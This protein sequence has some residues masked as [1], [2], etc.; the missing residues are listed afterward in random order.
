MPLDVSYCDFKEGLC[1]KAPVISDSGIKHGLHLPGDS[2][3]LTEIVCDNLL[4]NQIRLK[5]FF[6]AHQTKL[7]TL[8]GTGKLQIACHNGFKSS[9]SN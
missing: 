7:F 6:V 2:T 5:E 1:S 3:E 4:L 9:G 8:L